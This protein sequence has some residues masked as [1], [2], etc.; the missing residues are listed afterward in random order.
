MEERFVTLLKTLLA[1]Y[2]LL[3][4]DNF[5]WKPDGLLLGAKWDICS[6]LSKVLRSFW[7]IFVRKMLPNFLKTNERVG[8]AGVDEMQIDMTSNVNENLFIDD[9]LVKYNKLEM[10]NWYASHD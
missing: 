8:L 5:T 1:A 7:S 3:S 4:V 2:A 10:F 9:V 6:S